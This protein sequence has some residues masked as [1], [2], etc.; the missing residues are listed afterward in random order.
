MNKQLGFTLIEL[1]VVIAVLA[2]LASFAL[3]RFAELADDAHRASVESAGGS[4]IAAVN[5]VRAQWLANGVRAP[6]T[7]LQGYGE[8]NNVI[9]TSVDGWPTGVNGNNDPLAMTAAECND[10]WSELMSTNSLTASTVAGSDYLTSV[11]AG[12]CRY[13]YQATVDGYHIDYDPETGQVYTEL[14]P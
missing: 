10:L 14:N 1:V 12:D 8:P 5:L 11:V 6:V 4:Y 13:T 2:I 9:D 3:P 7:D